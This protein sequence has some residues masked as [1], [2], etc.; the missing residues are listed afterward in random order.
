WRG[1]E[2]EVEDSVV[3]L[4]ESVLRFLRVLAADR[5]CVVILEDLHWADPESLSVVEYLADNLANERVLCLA[6]ARVEERTA[7]VDLVRALHARRTA[8]VIEPARLTE[9]EVAEMVRT[10]LGSDSVPE[11]LAFA[12]RSDG[13]PFLVEELLAVAVA[14]G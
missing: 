4:S 1:P 10:C 8:E 3:T 13:V 9:A 5:G 6:T 2:P 12:K 11:V 7:A 14:S